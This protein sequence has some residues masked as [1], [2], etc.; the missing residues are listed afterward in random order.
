MVTLLHQSASYKILKILLPK[1]SICILRYKA[2]NSS[3]K[4]LEL[5]YKDREIWAVDRKRWMQKWISELNW[6]NV[7]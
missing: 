3:L 6:V 2:I 4:I 1:I 7:M 5:T